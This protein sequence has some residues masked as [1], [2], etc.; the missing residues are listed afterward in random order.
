MHA[1]CRNLKSSLSEFHSSLWKGQ[2]EPLFNTSETRQ[3]KSKFKVNHYYCLKIMENI[4]KCVSLL[5]SA[6]NF[7]EFKVCSNF[8]LAT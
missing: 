4:V 6:R 7:D 5:K 1:V 3:E 2:V 8:V